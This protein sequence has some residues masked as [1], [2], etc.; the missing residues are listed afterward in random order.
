MLTVERYGD[1]ERIIMWTRRS[2]AVGYHV[3]A[4]VTRGVVVDTGFPG[5][6]S[7]F[8][9]WLRARQPRGALVTH[10]HEDHAGNVDVVARLGVPVH[11]AAATVA[12]LR[13][14][15]HVGLY[16][17]LTWGR[18]R[19]VP[20]SLTSGGF[21]ERALALIPTPGHS[22]DHHV[23]WDAER[24][25]LFGGDLFLAVKVRMLAPWEDPRVHAA[26]LRAI[27]ALRP[28]RVFDA[29]RGLIPEPVAALAAKADWMEQTIGEIERLLAGGWSHA[30]IARAV[31]G[32]ETAL[33]YLTWGE[34]SHEHFVLTVASPRGP[35][36]PQSPPT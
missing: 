2:M 14:M 11:M 22:V 16:R 17:H 30:A 28:K 1:V 18:S 35:A 31:L 23:V 15:R 36:P 8:E 9:R 26:S 19:P 7:E 32:R 13:A 21:D 10:A 6:A 3:S 34:Y 27:V 33:R 25:T 12:E 24:E 20:A 29:H 4:F 5:I